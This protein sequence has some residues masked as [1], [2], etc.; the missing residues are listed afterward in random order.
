MEK[1]ATTD[2]LT[3]VFNRRHLFKLAEQEFNRASR[4][5]RSFSVLMIDIDHFKLINDTYGHGI[6]D[7]AL[8]RMT[9]VVTQSL[10]TVDFLGRFGG[11]EFIVFLPETEPQAAVEVVE[12]MRKKIAQIEL[13]QIAAAVI[14]VSIGV[15]SY[16]PN[17]PTIDLVLQ[18]ADAALYEAKHQGRNRVIAP[19][20]QV[21]TS[22]SACKSL[23][24][25]DLK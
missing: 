24:D 22:G 14:T 16:H 17:D 25:N 1:L 21:P 6:G 9:E 7:D 10:R 20:I 5:G 19:D 12:R 23:E 18:R 4:Y 8:K 2:P 11:E 3:G 15:A 13:E